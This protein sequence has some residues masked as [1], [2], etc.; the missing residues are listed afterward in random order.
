[1]PQKERKVATRWVP[2]KAS[3]RS[4]R[5]RAAVARVPA[6]RDGCHGPREGAVEWQ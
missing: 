6:R 4:G 2:K 3:E 5:R 1:M